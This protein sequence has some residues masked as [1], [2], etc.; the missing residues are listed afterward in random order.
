MRLMKFVLIVSLL[1]ATGT[2]ASGM[3]SEMISQGVKKDDQSFQSYVLIN[4]KLDENSNQLDDKKRYKIHQFE[5]KAGKKVTVHLGSQDFDSYLVLLDVDRK[6]VLAQDNDS[7]GGTTSLVSVTLPVTGLYT[8]FVISRNLNEIGTYQLKIWDE[9]YEKVKL[10]EIEQLYGQVS[11]LIQR[12]QFTEAIPISQKILA[13][14]KSLLGRSINVSFSLNLLASLYEREKR[15]EEAEKLLKEAF[16]IDKFFLGQHHIL[17]GSNQSVL[18]EIYINQG[19]YTEAEALY[20]ESLATMK[21]FMQNIRV[22][23][24]NAPFYMLTTSYEDWVLN[25]AELYKRQGRYK[26]A[27]AVLKEALIQRRSRAISF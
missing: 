6:K 4:D 5:G 17:F 25:M 19:R 8:V 20:A 9:V 18:A 23:S 3:E 16:L 15:Y 11:L 1:L 2:N 14:R 27:E 26:D 24:S 10:K 22:N 12:R 7:G 13:L 21:S